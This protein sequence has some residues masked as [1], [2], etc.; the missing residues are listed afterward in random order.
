MKAWTLPI[1][2]AANVYLLAVM[3]L[4]ATVIYPGFGTVDAT[5]FPA[6]YKGFTGRI[7][8]PVVAMEFVAFLVVF[9]LYFARPDTTPAWAVHALVGLGVAYFAITFGWHL[10]SHRAL[11]A[12]DNSSAALAPLLASQW[13]R[14]AV[15]LARAGLTVWLA[16]RPA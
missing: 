8:L 6:M 5:A 4:F 16:T 3:V 10:P 13:A 2:S 7:G 14:T 15:Q 1:C 9:S 12:G 11:A